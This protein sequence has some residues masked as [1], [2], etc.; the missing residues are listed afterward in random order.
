MPVDF[1]MLRTKAL[2]AA[3]ALMLL[4]GLVCCYH[5]LPRPVMIL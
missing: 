3:Y 2:Y 4:F 1:R 5:C